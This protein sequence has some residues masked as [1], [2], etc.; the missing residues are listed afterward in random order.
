MTIITTTSPIT[1]TKLVPHGDAGAVNLFGGDGPS[2]KD[3]L[4]SVNP[5]QQLPVVG[6]LYRSISGD[7]ISTASQLAGGAIFGGPI[8]LALAAGGALFEAIIGGDPIEQAVSYAS[9]NT[10]QKAQKAYLVPI[11]G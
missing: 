1:P 8:G 4:D 9:A 3:V 2:F 6:S 11:A 10:T 5:L 7:S